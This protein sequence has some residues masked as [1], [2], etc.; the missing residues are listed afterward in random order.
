LIAYIAGTYGIDALPKLLRGFAQYENWEELAP[1]VLGVSAAAPACAAFASCERL[2]PGQHR[3]PYDAE[4]QD[5]QGDDD[6]AQLFPLKAAG[7]AGQQQ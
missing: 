3:Q 4:E 6:G 2:G 7:Q 5:Q 1:A